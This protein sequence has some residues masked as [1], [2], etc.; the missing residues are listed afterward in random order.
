M[1]VEINLLPKKEPR[2][3][4]LLFAI[5]TFSGMILIGAAFLI[6]Q[7]NEKK[8]ELANVENQVQLTNEILEAKRTKLADFQSASSVQE[9]EK[10]IKWAEK[11]PYNLVYV[12]QKLTKILPE[13]G[14]LTEFNLEKDSIINLIIQFDTKSEAA[15]YLNSLLNYK[16]IDEAVITKEKAGD[17]EIIN[18]KTPLSDDQLTDLAK[19]N[20]FPRYYAEYE[21]RLNIAEL[22]QAYKSEMEKSKEGNKG[23]EEGGDS[24]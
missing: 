4:S 16:W 1:L 22:K 24:P 7:M 8:E 20:F 13:R 12:L 9:L 2:N 17:W 19:K 11:Q 18:N 3:L 23:E 10:A 6:W 5:V 14:F 21:I 15:Y